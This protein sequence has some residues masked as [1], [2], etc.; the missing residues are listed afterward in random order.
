MTGT[1]VALLCL[2]VLL[3]ER[4][5]ADPS[6]LPPAFAFSYGEHETARST[7]MGGALSALGSGTTAAFSNPAA[8]ALSKIYHIE[9]VGQFTPEAARQVYGGIIVDTTR[10][11]AGGISVVGG[12]IDP[13]GI[14]RSFIDVRLPLSLSISDRLSIGL[15]GRYLN[16]DQEGLGPL[17]DSRASGGLL[18]PDDAPTG[19]DALLNTLTF[20]AGLNVSITDGL[21]IAA[22][23]HN[24]TYPD[25]GLLPT[26][27]GGGIGY[28]TED[29]SVEIDAVADLTSWGE[30]TPRLMVGG[31]YLI[32]DRF[33]IRLGYRYDGLDLAASGVDTSSHA[34][35][36]G[37]G[38]ID[39]R[40]SVEAAVRRTLVGPSATMIGVSLAY[41]LES[42]GLVN[43]PPPE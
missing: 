33:P 2:L 24:L 28:G 23:G 30:P 11:V 6:E 5:A 4:A 31:E 15:T 16:L 40:F 29:F 3:S 21:R 8:M 41:F 22:V 1:A 18:D 20:D 9:A 10:V 26:V 17:G 38:Y 37:V 35:A 39:P 25:N 27:V 13:D 43:I 42:T 19:R 12:F 32:A 14:D 7:A 36:A 34:L